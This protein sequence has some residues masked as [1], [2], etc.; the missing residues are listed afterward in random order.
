MSR[1]NILI[2]QVATAQSLSS[3]FISSPTIISYMDNMS[4]QINCTTTDSI[5]SF[6]LQISNDYSIDNLTGAVIN[7]GNWNPIPLG[8][9]T[10]TV[11]AN[12]TVIDISLTQVPF[13]AIRLAYTSTTAGTGTC[14]IYFVSKQIGG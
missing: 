6:A 8:G 13:S 9:G 14:N 4:Y 10:P 12:D 11:N 3:S 5:G 1:K 2:Q 7:P